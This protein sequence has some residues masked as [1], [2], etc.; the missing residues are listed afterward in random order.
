MALSSAERRSA[1][2]TLV[3]SRRALL[4][5]GAFNALSAR[6]AADT[7]FGALYITGAGVTNMFS[8]SRISGLSA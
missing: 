1:F 7:G 3:E 6:V 4:V 2:R 5:P 8:G